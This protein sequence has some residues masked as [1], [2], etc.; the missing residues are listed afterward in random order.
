MV[1]HGPPNTPGWTVIGGRREGDSVPDLP[2]DVWT[3]RWARTDETIRVSDPIHGR[4][5]TLDVTSVAAGDRVVTFAVREVS[6][7]V[8]LFALPLGN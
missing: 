8:Y 1:P 6:N 2:E 3:R 7:G 5:L 4:Q